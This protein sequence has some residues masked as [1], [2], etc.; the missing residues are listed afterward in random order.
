M[1]TPPAD[2]HAAVGSRSPLTVPKVVIRLPAEY[3]VS[4]LV[5]AQSAAPQHPAD[6]AVLHGPKGCQCH[7][8]AKE[9]E[10]QDDDAHHGQHG[11]VVAEL[12]VG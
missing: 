12:V 5:A 3:S 7:A 1:V 2:A 11:G 6:S 10:E 9:L 4:V 8:G